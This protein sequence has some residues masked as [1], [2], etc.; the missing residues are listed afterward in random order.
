MLPAYRGSIAS[1][2]QARLRQLAAGIPN[3][4]LRIIERAGHN[5]QS[6]RPAETLAAVADFLCP[7]ASEARWQPVS[8]LSPLP[9]R[10][11]Q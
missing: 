2:G 9:A 8:S 3:A 7:T 4:R 5:P 6:E 10:T 11:Q 1:R